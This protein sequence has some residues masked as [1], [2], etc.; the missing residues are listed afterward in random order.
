MSEIKSVE[1][2]LIVEG[3]EKFT[4]SW[5]VENTTL[6]KVRI[7]ERILMEAQQKLYQALNK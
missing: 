7:V 4:N 6:E 1:V 2:A 5:L 3:E